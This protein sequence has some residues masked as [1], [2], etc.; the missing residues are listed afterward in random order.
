MRRRRRRHC[1]CF[2]VRVRSH[3]PLQV[4][5]RQ[6]QQDSLRLR[7]DADMLLLGGSFV[8]QVCAR[9][10]C[11]SPCLFPVPVPVMSLA[12]CTA[13]SARRPQEEEGRRRKEEEE[14]KRTYP[15][16]G[17]PLYMHAPCCC[18]QIP[19]FYVAYYSFSKRVIVL[20]A[21]RDSSV[22]YPVSTTQLVEHKCATEG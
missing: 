18:R 21:M 22:H 2:C 16:T 7:P 1:L 6:E 4:H 14:V 8:I 20:F 12:G 13:A 15:D 5:N 9:P 11:Q 17:P 3:A 19:I 10:R